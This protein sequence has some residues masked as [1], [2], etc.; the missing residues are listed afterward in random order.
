MLPFFITGTSDSDSCIFG[1]FEDP[2]CIVTFRPGVPLGNTPFM[3]FGC[4]GTFGY[5]VAP[6][7]RPDQHLF[8]DWYLGPPRGA[9][10][11]T[12]WGFAFGSIALGAAVVLPRDGQA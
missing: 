6:N 2:T 5:Y 1:V 9:T 7:R 11:S 4:G 10:Q 3:L 12:K 8:Y